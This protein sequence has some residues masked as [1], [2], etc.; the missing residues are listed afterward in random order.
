MKGYDIMSIEKL[1]PSMRNCIL[2]LQAESVISIECKVE[3][4]KN[5]RS[6]FSKIFKSFK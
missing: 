3:N 4:K 6:L 1:S 5:N 2:G